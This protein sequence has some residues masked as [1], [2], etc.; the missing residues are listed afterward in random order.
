[1]GLHIFSGR[2]LA[3]IGVLCAFVGTVHA[4]GN[5][6]AGGYSDSFEVVGKV[7]HPFRV[8][9]HDLSNY[10]TSSIEVSYYSGQQGFLTRRYTGVLLADLLKTAVVQ[11]DPAVKG[12]ILRKYVLVTASDCYEAVLAVADLLP[13]YGGQQ[14]LVAY[15][16]GEGKPLAADGFATLVV[17]GDK[18]ASRYVSNIVRI[19]VRSAP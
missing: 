12:D 5:S 14:V 1:M 4:T 19:R 16:D 2:K 8:A 13:E 9:P 3:V 18:R 17:P 7:A 11:T 15:A 6:C 10:P